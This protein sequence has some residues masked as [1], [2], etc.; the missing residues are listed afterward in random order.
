MHGQRTLEPDPV[1]FGA[2]ASSG[3]AKAR[4]LAR[5]LALLEAVA[6]APT[7]PTVA[8]L[9]DKLALPRATVYRLVEWFLGEGFLVREPARKRLVVGHR[10][11]ALAFDALHAAVAMAPRRSLLEALVQETGETC[12]IGTIDGNRII[13]LDRVE[14]ATW[15]LQ[16]HLTVG[17]RVP[18]HA[19]A[20]GKLFLALAPPRQRRALLAA[21]QPTPLTPATI[22]DRDRLEGELEIIRHQ[23]FAVDDQEF[24]AGVVA[25]AV[26][27]VNRRG[28][29]RA[30]LA[31]QA[32]EAR[33]SAAAAR[34]HLPHLR[35]AAERLAR[36]F[37]G[38]FSDMPAQPCGDG[39][40]DRPVPDAR[41]GDPDRREIRLEE[42]DGFP[43]LPLR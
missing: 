15:P 21:V 34:Q 5:S 18:L 31:V 26:P 10:L 12:H 41:T 43:S 23:G 14:S 27:I 38:D 2:V 30:S 16:L 22:T 28:E 9:I 6:A 8:D 37:A 20:I 42:L 17:A 3:N 25:L 11:S 32:P 40:R 33:L 24:L 29:I 19:T 13:Y 39:A 36:T 7:P 35:A 1:A 4:T